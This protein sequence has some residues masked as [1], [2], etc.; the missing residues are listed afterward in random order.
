VDRGH[1]SDQLTLWWPER[2]RP[3]AFGRPLSSDPVWRLSIA[4]SALVGLGYWVRG[5]RHLV[6]WSLL[7]T[8][9]TRATSLDARLAGAAWSGSELFLVLW[10]CVGT[11]RSIQRLRRRPW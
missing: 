10:L 6:S 11:T 7:G 2:P 4:V 5:S 9:Y 8:W 3:W 1:D